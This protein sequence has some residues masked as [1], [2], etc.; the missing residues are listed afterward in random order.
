LCVPSPLLH[1]HPLPS[2]FPSLVIFAKTKN[3][4]TTIAIVKGITIV[5]TQ[6]GCVTH[7]GYRMLLSN[8]VRFLGGRLVGKYKKVFVDER[9]GWKEGF[10]PSDVGTIREKGNADDLEVKSFG[11]W[12]LKEVRGKKAV[13]WEETAKE[14]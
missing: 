5:E 3:K 9:E 8:S 12:G 4:L 10:E 2:T 14:D 7:K 11:I 13:W 1:P 6:N